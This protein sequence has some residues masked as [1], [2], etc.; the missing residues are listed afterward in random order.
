MHT[1]RVEK[2][3][4]SLSKKSPDEWEE[5]ETLGATLR[6]GD[7]LQVM[8][9]IFVNDPNAESRQIQDEALL[10]LQRDEGNQ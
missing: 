4:R 5:E 8:D 7:V 3:L 9:A 1:K 2:K 6:E 10:E